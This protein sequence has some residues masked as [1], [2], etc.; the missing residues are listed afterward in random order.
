MAEVDGAVGGRPA[1]VHDARVALRRCAIL[2]RALD[3]I[4]PGAPARAVRTELR[5]L[6]AA[7]APVRDLDVALALLPPRSPAAR[8]LTRQR[9]AAQRLL[10]QTLAGPPLDALRAAMGRLL[11]IE[12]TRIRPNRPAPPAGELADGAIAAAGHKARRRLHRPARTPA[13]RHRLRIA[14]RRL[15]LT[16]E[17]LAPL[18]KPKHRRV[19]RALR[20]AVR[21]L[22]RLH[23]VELLLERGAGGAA[24]RLQKKAARRLAKAGA[25]L[26]HAGLRRALRA[27]R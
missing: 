15:A 9:A 10:V 24:E 25:A 26:Q 2:L 14:L 23:D 27:A 22:G 11:R 5:R 16:F 3:P 4:R 19:P 17:G 18:R 12:L 1:A 20:K 6:A 7:L 21:A 8:A 13:E